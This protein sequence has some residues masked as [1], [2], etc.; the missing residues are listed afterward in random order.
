[1]A[2]AG[3]L[4]TRNV[5]PESRD[6][7]PVYESPQVFDFGKGPLMLFVKSSEVRFVSS[8]SQEVCVVS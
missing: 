5:Q 7:V 4:L 6:V 1:M 3:L 8:V 2:L